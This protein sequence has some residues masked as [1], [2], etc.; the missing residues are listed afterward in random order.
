MV[1]NHAPLLSIVVAVYTKERINDICNLIKSIKSQTYNN[2]EIVFIVGND[3]QLVAII[4][5][6]LLLDSNIKTKY[7]LIFNDG[8]YKLNIQRNMGIDNANGD[9]IAFVD[10]DAVLTD[11]WAEAVVDSFNDSNVIGATGPAI[12]LWEDKNME[13][14][15]REF[16]WLTAC[17]GWFDTSQKHLVRNAW[18]M[19][20]AFRKEA[21]E[22]AGKFNT[23]IGMKEKK[24]LVIG[25][26]ELS[27]RIRDVTR[28]NIIF[29]PK[30]AIY[31]NV[32]KYRTSFKF[33]KQRAYSVGMGRVY[34]KKIF[35]NSEVGK[36]ILGPE[37]YLI[38]RIINRLLP[39]IALNI[40]RKPKWGLNQLKC[41][42]IVL[43]YTNLGFLAAY[44]QSLFNKEKFLANAGKI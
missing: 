40:V 42:F 11:K 16:W 26:V 37:K 31:H 29:H 1:K 10:D 4:N 3:Q 7:K 17:T 2:I 28:K 32:K 19:N 39:E 38:K 43:L 34:I 22:K 30:M 12:P 5:D 41:T 24:G 8:D 36:D 9:I 21:F 44:F 23:L 33:I 25:E 14:L 18:G 15:P 27:L 35:S 6:Y 13:W 20:M